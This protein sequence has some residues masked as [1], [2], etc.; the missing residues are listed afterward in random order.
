MLELIELVLVGID[1]GVS[2]NMGEG[3]TVLTFDEDETQD[4]DD[5]HSGE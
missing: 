3:K 4:L 5:N 1:G 2:T